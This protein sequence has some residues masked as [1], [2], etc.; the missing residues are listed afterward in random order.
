MVL[1]GLD[2]VEVFAIARLEA[3]VAIELELGGKNGISGIFATESVFLDDSDVEQFVRDD[4]AGVGSVVSPL[5][6]GLC[7]FVKLDSPDEL[8]D[9]MVEIEARLVGNV[10]DGFLTGVLELLNQILVGDLGEAS[11][12]LGVEV[13]VVN[14]ERS[15]WEGELSGVGIRNVKVGEVIELD[16]DFD[17]VV[18]ESDQGKSKTGVSAEPELERDVDSGLGLALALD[19][20]RLGEL[21]NHLF[22]SDFVSSRSGQLAPDLEPVAVVLVDSLTTDFNLNVV[23]EEVA[24]RINP[25]EAGCVL[26][27]DIDCR[28]RGLEVN[29]IDKIAI[30]RYSTGDTS[31]E[32]RISIEGLL[33]GL[34][35]K[36]GV[37]SVDDLEVGNLGITS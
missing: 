25:A 7:D 23:H 35:G 34:H 2:K 11:A 29:A 37:S 30:T 16:V 17:F 36:I 33:N 22:V 31:S 18:L 3:I 1:V 15:I 26:S 12:L 20:E 4:T 6:E 5:V 24:D 13:N 19:T 14:P 21:T 9:G 10:V 28:K 27:S 32:V 8:L